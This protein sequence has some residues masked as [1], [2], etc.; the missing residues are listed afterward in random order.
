MPTLTVGP[1]STFSTI[2]AAMAAAADNDTIQLEAGYSNETATVTHTGMIVTGEATSTGIVLQLGAGVATFTL[3]GTAPINVFDAADGDAITGNAGNNL[4]TV[5][6]GADA[7]DGG[8]GTNDRLVVDWRPTIGAVTGDSTT[9]FADG[10]SRSVTITNGTFEHLTILTGSG[11]DTITTGAG[12]DVI[13]TGEGA[14]VVTA[15]QGANIISGG[16]G[17]DT[18]TALDGGNVVDGFDGANTITTGA[19]NDIIRGGTGADTIVAGGGNDVISVSGGA[20]TSASGAGNDRL[21]VAYSAFNTGVT[22]GVASGNLATGYTGSF[23][24]LAGNSVGFQNT[25][26]FFITTGSGNDVLT[27]G[28]GNDVIMTGEGNSTVN[29]GHGKNIMHGGSGNDNITGLDGGN[30]IGGGDGANI[31]TSGSGND[32]IVSG[33]GGPDTISAGGGVDLITVRGGV[34]TS[35]AGAGNDRLVVNYSALD[36]I[37]TTSFTG[38]SLTG[39]YTGTVGDLIGNSVA[40]S[41]TENFTIMTGSGRDVLT[42]ADGVDVLRGGEGND[43]LNGAGGNDLLFGGIGNDRVNGGSGADRLHGY[44]G[45]DTLTGGTGRDFFDFNLASESLDGATRDTIVDFNHSEGDRIDLRDIDANMELAGNQTFKFIGDDTFA[46]YH[47]LHQNVIGMVRI[48]G[49]MVQANV[50]STLGPDF[51]INVNGASSL[52]AGDFFL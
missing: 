10:A 28:D 8:L 27:T 15:G 33:F 7:V 37:V 14:S 51:Q 36:A 3:G 48:G 47:S 52:V 34:D 22:G 21:F 4:I 38:G 17:A 42:T 44:G 1:T 32:V 26:N 40:F 24:D 23:A 35:D 19:G 29:G 25:E 12:D 39:G 18:I 49:G 2:A 16:S 41:G 9:N 46:H 45:K 43:V 50:N 13:A 30:N 6:D 20:D 31:L 11:A 5:T